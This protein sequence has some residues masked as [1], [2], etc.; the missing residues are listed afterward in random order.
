[1]N[2]AE[3]KLNHEEVIH[4]SYINGI[5]MMWNPLES[6]LMI[7]DKILD[8]LKDYDVKNQS[9]N[10]FIKFVHSDDKRNMM[11]FFSMNLESIYKKKKNYIKDIG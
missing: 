11:N 8:V 3:F 7:E 2:R 6:Q 10:K 5:T 9:V 4:S 1:M